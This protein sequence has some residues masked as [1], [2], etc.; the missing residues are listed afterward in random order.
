MFLLPL[1]CVLNI[2][3][4]AHYPCFNFI[5][6]LAERTY[7]YLLNP[8]LVNMRLCVCRCNLVGDLPEHVGHLHMALQNYSYFLM[9]DEMY[10]L[11]KRG[12]VARFVVFTLVRHYLQLQ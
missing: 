3:S 2:F 12:L 10:G 5:S 6:A 1:V 11:K 7:M 8:R 4:Y 9:A